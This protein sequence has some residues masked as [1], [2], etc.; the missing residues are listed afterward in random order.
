MLIR[1]SEGDEEAIFGLRGEKVDGRQHFEYKMWVEIEAEETP[2][3]RRRKFL[4]IV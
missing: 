1:N 4:A 2:V 3:Y